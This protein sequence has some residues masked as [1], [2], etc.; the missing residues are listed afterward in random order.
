MGALTLVPWRALPAN[1]PELSD[2][3]VAF[4]P[5]TLAR[6]P[7]QRAGV[8]AALEA[9]GNRAALAIA[10]TVPHRGGVL[11]DDAVDGLLLRAHRELQRL[12]EEF[13]HARRVAALVA[14]VLRALNRATGVR[15]SRVV[16]LGAGLGYVL[17]AIAHQRLLPGT[18]LVGVDFNPALIAEAARLAALEHLSVTFARTDALTVDPPADVYVST[19]VLHH[20]RGD[21]LAAFLRAQLARAPAFVHFD[22]QPSVLAPFGAWLFHRARFRMPLARH[23]GVL[24]AVR[25]HDA[26]TLLAAAATAPP[27]TRVA[28][29]GAHL[30]GRLPR[31]FHALVA[32]P[33]AA[34]AA[35][36]HEMGP[37]AARL[38]TTVETAGPA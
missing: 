28:I 25:A 33:A 38:G 4:E 36:T 3:I 18:Q 11:D 30:H 15:H 24:S 8:L 26:A 19:G 17:R 2:L 27:G 22:F 34:W 1:S 35:F 21:G 31:V 16:D 37:A 32:L 5:R 7:V 12:S 20:F 10:A 13:D 9:C 14:P 23:D 29:F 6:Q